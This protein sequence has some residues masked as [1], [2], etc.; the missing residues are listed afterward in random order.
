MLHSFRLAA[1]SL[2]YVAAYCSHQMV[3]FKFNGNTPIL[4]EYPKGAAR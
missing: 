4:P 3:V 2:R 1:K